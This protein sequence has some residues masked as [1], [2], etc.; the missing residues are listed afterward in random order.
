MERSSGG[1]STL[2]VGAATHVGRVRDNNEDGY[3]V[4]GNLLA[5]AD[6]MGGHNAGE[7]ASGTALAVLRDYPFSPRALGLDA[8][9]HDA[10]SP[11]RELLS[12]V[13]RAHEMLLALSRSNPALSGMGTTLTAALVQEDTIH[14]AH[15]GD[16]RLYIVRDGRL[17]PVTQDH[18]VAAEL[19]RAGQIDEEAARRHPLRHAVTRALGAD[20]GGELQVDLLT[21]ERR[22]GDGLLLCTDGL[23]SLVSDEDIVAVLREEPDVQKAVDA[24]V[25]L[26]LERGGIDNVTVVLALP[27]GREVTP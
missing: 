19:L 12:A 18:S 8:D 14:V 25:A 20:M 26:T 2:H 4:R 3:L 24:L 15:V 27:K 7:V 9:G 5:V 17:H 10:A 22:P 6:G 13:Q 16:S 11:G 23:N 21:V 1:N